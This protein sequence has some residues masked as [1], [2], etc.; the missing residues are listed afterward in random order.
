MGARRY[1]YTGAG[2]GG[3]RGGDEAGK[4]ERPAQHTPG[5]TVWDL[6]PSA[7]RNRSADW[8]LHS[9][10]SAQRGATPPVLATDLPRPPRRRQVDRCSRVVAV[11]GVG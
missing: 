7:C 8:Q 6:T 3:G 10:P 11:I 1:R 9:V 4:R 2:F 5:D